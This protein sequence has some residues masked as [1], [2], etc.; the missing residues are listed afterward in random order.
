MTD[1]EQFWHD[2][3]FMARNENAGSVVWGMEPR[4]S[5]VHFTLQ[6]YCPGAS[7][8]QLVATLAENGLRALRPHNLAGL[9]IW[10]T[11]S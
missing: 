4:G 7:L 10:L 5:E 3:L 6:G 1:S 2:D 11:A 8:S 9:T